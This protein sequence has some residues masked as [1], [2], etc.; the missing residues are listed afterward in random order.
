MTTPVKHAV[1]HKGRSR[2]AVVLVVAVA[3]GLLVTHCGNPGSSPRPIPRIKGSAAAL[4]PNPAALSN[5]AQLRSC[6][7]DLTFDPLT[8]VGDEQRLLVRDTVGGGGVACH[9]DPNHTCRHGPLAKIEPVVDADKRDTSALNQGA[10]IARLFLGNSETES[11][12]KLN[13]APGDTTYWWVQRQ[14]DSTA[15]SRFLRISQGQ[16]IDT[17][18]GTITIEQHPESTFTMSL[19]RFI[20]ADSDEKVQGS[21]GVAGCCR[22]P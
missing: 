4:C 6:V 11:Y 9:G 16:V 22:G 21:C 10:I 5:E 2:V 13:L 20:W 7:N 19:A 17:L 15:S 12:P 18:V 8:A 14:S 1:Q 3:L